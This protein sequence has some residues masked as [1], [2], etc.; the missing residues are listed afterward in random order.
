M[1]DYSWKQQSP[2]LV[3]RYPDEDWIR[4]VAQWRRGAV[5]FPPPNAIE[6]KLWADDIRN[7]PPARTPTPCYRVFVSHRQA[8]YDCALRTAWIA[9]QSLFDYWLDVMDLDPALDPQVRAI[10]TRLGRPLT[11]EEY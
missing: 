5:A 9:S 7:A 3:N 4:G 11:T 1:Y 2:D 10:E 6:A 8:D